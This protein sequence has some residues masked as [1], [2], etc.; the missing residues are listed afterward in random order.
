VICPGDAD[1]IAAVVPAVILLP[2]ADWEEIPKTEIRD[3]PQIT[4]IS[5]MTEAREP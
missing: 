5:Q 3:K 4:Q 2:K 1:S